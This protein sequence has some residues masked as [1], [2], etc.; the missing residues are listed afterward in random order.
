MNASLDH[1]NMDGGNYLETS[2][3][4]YLYCILF[5]DF[6]LAAVK[7]ILINIVS[8]FHLMIPPKSNN[9]CMQ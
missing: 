6:L 8:I 9:V 1:D 5:W 7:T 3:I 2:N 4:L